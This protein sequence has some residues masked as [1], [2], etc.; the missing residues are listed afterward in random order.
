MEQH[1]AAISEARR[2]NAHITI[3]GNLNTVLGTG[4]RGEMLEELV[5]AFG[6]IIANDAGN[7]GDGSWTFES[8]IGIRRCLDYILVSRSLTMHEAGPSSN[9]SLG[10]DHRAVRALLEA[11][12]RRHTYSHR[13]ASAKGWRPKLSTTGVAE[14]YH[15]EPDREIAWNHPCNMS[16]IEVVI[17][18]AAAAEHVTDE[19]GRDKLEK[20]WQQKEVRNLVAQRKGT[21]TRQ[22]RATA[23][24][25]I[26]KAIRKHNQRYYNELTEITLK[27]FQGLERIE[28]AHMQLMIRQIPAE[29][30]EPDQFRLSGTFVFVKRCFVR[31]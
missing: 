4:Y 1:R 15:S 5:D 20:P 2:C 31:T 21:T 27:R 24:N 13:S 11:P 18:T 26:R 22:E 29:I 10:S 14:T 17:S 6:S 16:D 23:T 7:G 3:R 28:K 9:L 25:S 30:C 19:D 12:P 8:T